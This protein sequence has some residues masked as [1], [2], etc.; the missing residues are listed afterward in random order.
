MY[1]I[2]DRHPGPGIEHPKTILSFLSRSKSKIIYCFHHTGKIRGITAGNNRLPGLKAYGSLRHSLMLLNNL[3]HPL[4]AVWAGH[5]PYAQFL[6]HRLSFLQ[7]HMQ[8]PNPRTLES[9]DPFIFSPS[10]VG[11]FI[12]GINKFIDLVLSFAAQDG[13]TDAA[14]HM[15][16]HD[17]PGNAVK[18]PLGGGDLV[19]DIDTV[20]LLF[21]H[22]HDA[23]DLAFDLFEPCQGIFLNRF[24]NH[25]ASLQISVIPIFDGVYISY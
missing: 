22:T 8:H 23:P 7:F 16:L 20:L 3:F 10:P 5:A 9:L 25:F 19:Y 4:H 6:L 24:V 13:L 12:Y 1:I 18:C 14:F 21:N 17:H 15:A 2:C 11:V